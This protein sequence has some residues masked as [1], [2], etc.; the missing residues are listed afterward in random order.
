MSRGWALLALALGVGCQTSE[1]L[2]RGDRDAADGQYLAAIAHYRAALDEQRL[3]RAERATFAAHLDAAAVAWVEK[4][5][6]GSE[7]AQIRDQLAAIITAQAWGSEAALARA[8]QRL[9]QLTADAWAEVEAAVERSHHLPAYARAVRLTSLLAPE[10]RLRA[11]TEEIRAA[12]I[13]AHA[14]RAA[15]TRGAASHLHR[16]V[17]QALGGPPAPAAPPLSAIGVRFEGDLPGCPWL[18]AG[19]RAR[20]QAGAAESS[21]VVSLRLDVESC[22]TTEEITLRR[23]PEQFTESVPAIEQIE[24]RYEAWERD[25]LCDDAPCLRFDPLGVCLAR[26]PVE[27]DCTPKKVTRSRDRRVTRIETV[28]ATRTREVYERVTRTVL[29][30]RARLGAQREPRTI[31]RTQEHRDVS[32]WSPSGARAF[33]S[34]VRDALHAEIVTCAATEIDAWRR[35]LSTQR[36]REVL[37]EGTE[38]AARANADAAEEGLA[39]AALSV[40]APAEA[41]A[42]FQARYGIDAGWMAILQ[43][44]AGVPAPPRPAVSL[45]LPPVDDEVARAVARRAPIASEST[46]RGTEL[47]AADGIDLYFEVRRPPLGSADR[48]TAAGFRI[49]GD[50]LFLAA[51]GQAPQLGGDTA[52]FEVEL[53]GILTDLE[54]AGFL[55]RWGFAGGY[56]RSPGG[57]DFLFVGPLYA[58]EAPALDWV[59]AELEVRL[60]FAQVKAWLFPVPGDPHVYTPVSVGLL[61]DLWQRFY[62]DARIRYF[63]GIGG[64]L[65]VGAAIGARL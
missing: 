51:S 60:N 43:S 64:Q 3:S 24:E 56:E 57:E 10:D 65:H 19:L 32:Y 20:F 41:L 22:S 36:V 28:T 38:A 9:A 4:T 50:R 33:T 53:S 15:A 23:E 47:L 46:K 21:T 40:P 48:A 55:F 27:V 62:L 13:E 54:K 8:R 5:S 25:P 39:A 16:L 11:R 44:R 35:E 26:A 17:V 30:A 52:G 61:F 37:H 63:I 31:Q 58:L 42:W 2:R 45:A 12:G 34:G 14:Q 7:R 1:Y 29:L 18:A 49:R 59:T 6:A